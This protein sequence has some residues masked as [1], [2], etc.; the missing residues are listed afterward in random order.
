MLIFVLLLLKQFLDPLLGA[1]EYW[2]FALFCLGTVYHFLEARQIFLAMDLE[3]TCVVFGA[4][5]ISMFVISGRSASFA[6]SELGPSCS[7]SG[8]S[9]VPD[10]FHLSLLRKLKLFRQPVH[11]IMRQLHFSWSSLLSC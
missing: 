2:K 8:S 5:L 9:G 4:L 6:R 7:G 1:P 3:I 10:C 11:I